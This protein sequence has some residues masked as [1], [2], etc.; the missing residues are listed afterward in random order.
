MQKLIAIRR[1]IFLTL[2]LVLAAAPGLA[3]DNWPTRPITVIVPSSA[4]GTVD[5]A[6]RIVQPFWEK[7]LGVP[8]RIVNRPGGSLAVGLTLIAEAK[9]DGS[10]IGVYASPHLEFT[11]ITQQVSYDVDSFDFIGGYAFD[12]GVIRIHVDSP[13]NDF[14][15]WIEWVKSQ[16]A[17]SVTISVSSLTSSNVL[18]L[19]QIEEQAG[20]EFNIIPYAGGNEARLA[21]VAKE[22]DA[23]HTQLFGSQNIAASTRV[24]AVHYRSNDW[25]E[26]SDNARTL[27]EQTGWRLGGT[28][29]GSGFLV[30]S[31]LQERYP[32]RYQ[33]LVDTYRAAIESADFQDQALPHVFYSSPDE[34]A[35][36]IGENAVNL[37]RFKELWE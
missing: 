25:P 8:L 37:S 20:V 14:N 35:S 6:A 32:E 15:E 4:G 29:S 17:G 18:G 27:N 36:E 1:L 12:P 21:V 3:Q 30:T 11:T 7:E 5:T 33:K 2:M 16:P 22:V 26:V 24:I 9:D 23:T 28:G 10:T 13:Y 19:K 31:A 34:V